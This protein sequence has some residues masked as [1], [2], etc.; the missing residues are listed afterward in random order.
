MQID[1]DL[2]FESSSAKVISAAHLDLDAKCHAFDKDILCASIAT[3]LIAH[4]ADHAYGKRGLPRRGRA[5]SRAKNAGLLL[6]D[7]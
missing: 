6:N 3:E 4:F 1:F 2:C 7:E 5:A